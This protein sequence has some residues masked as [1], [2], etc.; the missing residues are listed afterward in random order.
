M[1]CD[2]RR[3]VGQTPEQRR[4]EVSAA[5]ARLVQKLGQNIVRVVI[6]PQGQVTFAGWNDRDAVTDACAYRTLAAQSSYELRV[7][8]QRAEALQGKKVNPFVAATTGVHSHDEGA[9]WTSH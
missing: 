3:R 4:A 8:V 1:P 7:A 5:L 9:T 2:T 6:G